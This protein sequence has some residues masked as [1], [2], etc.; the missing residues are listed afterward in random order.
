MKAV[1]EIL[2]LTLPWSACS[3]HGTSPRSDKGNGLSCSPLSPHS[4]H[5]PIS[6]RGGRRKILDDV[7]YFWFLSSV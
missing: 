3:Q 7:L 4:S 2:W 1:F 6:P 5:Q